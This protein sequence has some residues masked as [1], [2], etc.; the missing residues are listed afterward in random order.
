MAKIKKEEIG[1]V[2]TKVSRDEMVASLVS[3]LNKTQK[4]GAKV[5]YFLDDHEDPSTVPDWVSTGST[6]LDLAI[7][8][9]PN[10]G[11]PAG[12]AVEFSGL[13]GC[14]TEDTIIEVI[15]N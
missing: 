9:K 6:L 8:N 11:L 3:A 14:V 2:R 15:V 13:E 5:A 10:G 7:S 4:D 12:R 1:E